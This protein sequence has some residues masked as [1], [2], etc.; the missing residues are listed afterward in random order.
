MLVTTMPI[1]R[2]K[3]LSGLSDHSYN[4]IFKSAEC[5]TNDVYHRDTFINILRCSL[6]YFFSRATYDLSKTNLSKVSPWLRQR[7]CPRQVEVLIVCYHC[8]YRH[9]VAVRKIEKRIWY[10][11]TSD[12][13]YQKL[14]QM[15]LDNPERTERNAIKNNIKNIQCARKH[16]II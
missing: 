15:N 2:G 8:N 14:W 6:L 10:N 1:S 12:V 3:C 13:N 5:N 9:M 4:P 11:H 16:T 7:F